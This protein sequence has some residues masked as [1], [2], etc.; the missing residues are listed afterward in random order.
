[1]PSARRPRAG[2]RRTRRPVGGAWGTSKPR[3]PPRGSR[4]AW[5]RNSCVE[6]HRK[7]VGDRRVSIR[8]AP[9]TMTYLTALLPVAH[10]V[11]VYAA[12]TR[13]A[14][15]AKATGDARGPRPTDGRRTRHTGSPTP[16]P[17]PARPPH[18]TPAGQPTAA[19]HRPTRHRQTRHQP[20]RQ[21]SIRHRQTRH[22]PARQRSITHRSAKTGR[23]GRPPP[24][25]RRDARPR[26]RDDHADLE[27]ASRN[28]A[29]PS[30]LPP[31]TA[32]MTPP[33]PAP[34]IAAPP[35]RR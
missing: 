28:S 27:P 23:S 14:D 32:R 22:R 7:A 9:D 34:M 21:R 4:S 30:P 24:T 18:R 13:H 1:M 26:P 11:A 19:G 35:P 20:A 12:L 2:G 5:T 8:P 15:T 6:R 17:R 10:G 29:N 31:M 25:A 3:T 33:M 16:M